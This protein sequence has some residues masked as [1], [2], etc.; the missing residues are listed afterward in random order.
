[1]PVKEETPERLVL[2]LTRPQYEEHMLGAS[3]GRKVEK[4]EK[5][6]ARRAQEAERSR[7]EKEVVAKR[8]EEKAKLDANIAAMMARAAELALPPKPE[9]V[10]PEMPS[11]PLPDVDGC[12]LVDGIYEIIDDDDD[13][14]PI[15]SGSGNQPEEEKSED[16][17]EMNTD[18]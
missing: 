13:D 5:R 2:G 6:A 7:K 12:R 9:P 8:L 16:A 3:L 4:E 17:P 10:E 1:M 15:A 14:E 11:G 18:A